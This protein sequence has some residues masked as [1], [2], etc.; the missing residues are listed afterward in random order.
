METTLVIGIVVIA[1]LLL[2]HMVLRRF[3]MGRPHGKPDCGCVSCRSK[4]R[5]GK[6]L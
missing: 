3:G 5:K 6:A 1:H 4:P 2:I